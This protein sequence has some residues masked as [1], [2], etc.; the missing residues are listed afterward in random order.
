MAANTNAPGAF[1]AQLPRRHKDGGTAAAPPITMFNS[2]RGFQPDGVD[3]DV[4]ESAQ[5]QEEGHRPVE[6]QHGQH[7]DNHQRQAHP[8]HPAGIGNVAVDQRP[9]ACAAH[10]AVP[11]ALPVL[12]E[13]RSSA[14]AI[15]PVSQV[16]GP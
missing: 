3:T 8:R 1:Q 2:V 11:V 16:R 4:D 5:G 10:E 7:R 14:A 9:L 15:P 13:R 12:V 6:G